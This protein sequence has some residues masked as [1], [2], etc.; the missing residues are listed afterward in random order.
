MKAVAPALLWLLLAPL[1]GRAGEPADIGACVERRQPEPDSI[2]AARITARDR[3]GNKSI[4]VVKMFGRRSDAGQRQLLVEFVEPEDLRGTSVLIL[5]RDG[6]HNDIYLRAVEKS[7]HITG[8]DRAGQLFG[9]D[10]SYEDLAFL[11]GFSQPGAW[12]RLE[13]ETLDER[14]VYVVEIRPEGSAYERILSYVDKETCLP[15]LARLYER[16]FFVRKELTIDAK[17]VK[18]IGESWIPH[19]ILI[20]D[21]RDLTTTHVFVDRTQQ[22]PLPDEIFAEQ[23]IT[24]AQR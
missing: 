4:T 24:G 18:K 14:P 5:E 3:Q 7:T 6:D 22:G 16:R 9:T 1:S 11:E 13:D 23:A 15:V 2:R 12:K 17:S 21:L 10:F 20:R 8:M 19:S